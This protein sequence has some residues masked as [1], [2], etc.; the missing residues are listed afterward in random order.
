MKSEDRLTKTTLRVFVGEEDGSFRHAPEL[1]EGTIDARNPIVVA[2]ETTITVTASGAARNRLVGVQTRSRDVGDEQ[3]LQR[4]NLAC[5]LIDLAVDDED[6]D[7]ADQRNQEREDLQHGREGRV[8]LHRPDPIMIRGTPLAMVEHGRR[9]V[10]LKRIVCR[11]LLTLGL[12]APAV[13]AAQI[14]EQDRRNTEIRHTDRHYSMRTYTR[15][16]WDRR[17]AFL[18][19][20][21]LF[22][23]GLLPLPEKTPLNPRSGETV[24][25][26]DYSVSAVLLETYPGFFL[27]GNLYRPVGKPGPFPAVVSPHGHWR[28]GRFENTAINSV[29][30]RAISL[31]R[32]GYTVFAYD[33]VG[34]NDTRQA[35]HGFAGPRE[36][37]WLIG[38]L[39]LQL[40]NSIRVVD[41]LES[42]PDV[43]AGRIGVTGASG[44]ATQGFLLAAVDD[45]IGYSAPV[46]MVSFLMQGG[47]PC[48]NAPLLRIDTH[49]VEFAAAFAP[50]PQLLVSATGD[51][52]VNTP[53]EEF[54]AVRGIYRL[55]DGESNVEWRQFDSP[56]NYH[57]DSREAVY[58]F[59]G[60]HILGDADS[61]RFVERSYSPEQLSSLLYLWG[62]T[63][64]EGAVDLPELVRRRIAAAEADTAALAVRDAATLEAARAAFRERLGLSIHAEAPAPDR[65][66]M[67]RRPD[68]TL[69]LGRQGA[70]DR[71]PAKLLNADPSAETGTGP[72]TRAVSAAGAPTLLVH[73]EGVAA[74]ERSALARALAERGAPLLLIDAFQTGAAVAERDVAGAGRNAE[75]YYHVFNR[76]DDANRVQDVL[77][78]IA[79]LRRQTGGETVN[80]VG[81][82][83]AGL[84]VLLAAA[85]DTGDLTAVADLDRFDAS[86]DAAYVDGL[87]IPGLRRAG[88]VRAAAPLL[89]R[90]RLLLH[91]VHVRF[92]V[93]WFEESFEAAGKSEDLRVG[94]GGIAAEALVAWLES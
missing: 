7:R 71:I 20:Q 1:V 45:R 72:G 56:H 33:M 82:G 40:W 65:V 79:F 3:L 18:R 94:E 84:W 21:I 39:G 11:G 64:P 13:S 25:H 85:L 14:P 50:Q 2:A 31:A 28:Y 26:D 92:P 87:F 80:V 46:N 53:A 57:R 47:S 36:E 86:D 35:P 77:T 17:A 24:V 6:A 54:P 37:L 69:L 23:A 4:P 10:L 42:L 43:D 60:K 81:M 74:A 27:G 59:F 51:W 58:G 89:S 22:S 55:L 34:W 76:S 75:A 66:V 29:P 63:L 15:G 61:S 9:R 68:G 19:K 83:Q 88:D 32:Q 70:G 16:E 52:T 93:Q 44:G 90:G 12:L 73:T 38:T 5:E 49:N 41:Y 8:A 78:A 67:Q 48:E 91:D 62:R 30:A